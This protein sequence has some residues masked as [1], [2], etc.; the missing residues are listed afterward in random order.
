MNSPIVI[1]ELDGL[2]RI[3]IPVSLRRSL[4]IDE[5]AALEILV[6]DDSIILRRHDPSC[7]FCGGT[8]KVA[9]YKGK[10]VCKECLLLL[11]KK[12]L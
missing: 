5:H 7:L 12:A 1:R 11:G 8:K 4:N 2:G 6:D 3:V 10:N 9:R